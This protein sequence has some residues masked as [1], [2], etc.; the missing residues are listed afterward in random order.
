MT[1]YTV[2]LDGFR[3]PLDV[4][5]HL[6]ESQELAITQV[7][8]AQVADQ[9]MQYINETP[10]LPADSIADFLVIASK[11]LLIKSKAL[12]P[13]LDIEDEDAIDLEKQLRMYKR[14]I[15]A[16]RKIEQL[17]AQKNFTFTRDVYPTHTFEGFQPPKKQ[18][19][20][21]KLQTIFEALLKRIEPV[22][23]LQKRV[24]ERVVTIKEKIQ[25]IRDR[26]LQQAYVS[27]KQSVL[28]FGTKSEKIVSFL[29]V[30]EL[31]KQKI[32]DIQ[33]DAFLG[34]IIIKKAQGAE[35]REVSTE[36]E[37]LE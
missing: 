14:F 5:L 4:L 12:L 23:V 29:A 9:Y 31:A 17:V 19:T 20:I 21:E 34:D 3:G 30:L 27:F 28:E 37:F 36:T 22:E 7:S 11:L 24:I 18:L 16:S 10:S 32:I 15:D 35:T 25:Q 13:Q 1:P 6:I 33:Q 8:L 26:I 2:A